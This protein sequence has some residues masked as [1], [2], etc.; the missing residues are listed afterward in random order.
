MKGV[1][2]ESF[3]K[4][5]PVKVLSL[6]QQKVTLNHYS[7]VK[8]IWFTQLGHA[9][10]FEAED[11]TKL[12]LHIGIDA[13]TDKEGYPKTFKPLIKINQKNDVATDIE[14]LENNSKSS[15]TPIIALNESLDGR[16]IEILK[17]SGLVKQGE[18]LFR[19]FSETEKS[20]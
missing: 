4:S 15:I 12:L 17:T 10:G 8:L 5:C 16:K 18:P 19:I 6:F 9:Y 13:A 3:K 1:P 2:D 20:E 11:S 14:A 7:K